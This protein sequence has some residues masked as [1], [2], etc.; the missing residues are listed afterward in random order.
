MLDFAS[1]GLLFA[2]MQF[3]IF[4]HAKTGKAAKTTILRPRIL[5]ASEGFLIFEQSFADSKLVFGELQPP[6]GITKAF[7]AIA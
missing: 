3:S 6:R 7:T 5:P 4:P 1:F 2:G